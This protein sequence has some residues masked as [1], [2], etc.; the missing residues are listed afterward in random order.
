MELHVVNIPLVMADCPF[1][2]FLG[3][4]RIGPPEPHDART[5]GYAKASRFRLGPATC[6]T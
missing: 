5:D 2:G 4:N 3:A 1:G 6:R